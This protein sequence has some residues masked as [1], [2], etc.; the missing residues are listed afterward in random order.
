MSIVLEARRGSNAN[1]SILELLCH[2][3]A[4]I[5]AI[6]PLFISRLAIV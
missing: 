1:V 4:S 6:F 2:G 3:L 5:R